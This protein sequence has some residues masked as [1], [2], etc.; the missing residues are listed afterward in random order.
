MNAFYTFISRFHTVGETVN[1]KI[2]QQK[3]NQTETQREKN[4]NKNKLSSIHKNCGT[5]SEVG[6]YTKLKYQEKKENKAEE[7]FEGIMVENF[8]K[9][10]KVISTQIQEAQRTLNK[11]DRK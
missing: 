11:I 5:M 10:M 6:V 7:I 4:N 1:L 3:L 2:A 8:P 9:L